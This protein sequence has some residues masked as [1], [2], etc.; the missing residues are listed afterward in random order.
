MC[1]SNQLNQPFGLEKLLHLGSCLPFYVFRKWNQVTSGQ[2]KQHFTPYRTY[3]TCLCPFCVMHVLS[4]CIRCSKAKTGGSCDLEVCLPVSAS[5]TPV[6]VPMFTAFSRKAPVS[7]KWTPTVAHLSSPAF[8]LL[9][10]L[11]F[12]SVV[13]L[14]PLLRQL[15]STCQSKQF[16]KKYCS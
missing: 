8:T 4:W 10:L 15:E 1:A 3:L 7:L 13:Q 6:K 5:R 14:S 9:L 11:S 12:T 16:L 2:S